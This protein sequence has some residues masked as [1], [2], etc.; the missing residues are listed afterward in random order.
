MVI[1][2]SPELNIPS[3]GQCT[4]HGFFR[5]LTESI[6]VSSSCKKSIAIASEQRQLPVSSV[7]AAEGQHATFAMVL[8]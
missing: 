2:A 7:L 3:C 1:K 6:S 4:L 5:I 8:C